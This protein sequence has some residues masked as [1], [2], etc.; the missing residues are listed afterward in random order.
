MPFYEKGAIYGMREHAAKNRQPSPPF[1]ENVKV[2][3][4]KISMRDGAEIPIR[5]YSPAKT[6][7]KASPLIVNYHGGGFMLG[8]LEMGGE[9][10][11]KMV[12]AFNA[13]VVDVDYRMAP[14]HPFPTAAHDSFDALKWVRVCFSIG[15]RMITENIGERPPKMLRL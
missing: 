1:P 3:D 13:V 8:D 9:F 4:S 6:D 15:V 10:G 14:E 7:G 2:V 12:M 5:I 11:S